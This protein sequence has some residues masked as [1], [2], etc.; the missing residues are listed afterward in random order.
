MRSIT[1]DILPQKKRKKSHS[2]WWRRRY[3]W[4]PAVTLLAIAVLFGVIAA[5]RVPPMIAA[6]KS[7]SQQVDVLKVA[8]KAQDMAA[9][10]AGLPELQTRLN[11]LQSQVAWLA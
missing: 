4:L 11:T 2:Q 6:A 3:V 5:W 10:D 7:V 1:V 9:L 8:A